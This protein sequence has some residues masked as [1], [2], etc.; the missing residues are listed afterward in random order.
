[1][2]TT[3]LV[4]ALSLNFTT[5]RI[6]N[7]WYWAN[8]EHNSFSQASSRLYTKLQ[9]HECSSLPVIS[10]YTV[11]AHKLRHIHAH[12]HTCIRTHMYT[13][14]GTHCKYRG[15]SHDSS[16]MINASTNRSDTGWSINA[17]LLWLSQTNNMSSFQSSKLNFVCY[18]QM[19][20]PI[21]VLP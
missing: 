16:I 8:S 2:S 12:V 14:T 15:W 1:M 10:T 5:V 17:I 4:I 9:V 21:L 20:P 3:S 7:L 19:P 11:W 6:I 18:A 13:H